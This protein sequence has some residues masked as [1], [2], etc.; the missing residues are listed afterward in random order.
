M[1]PADHPRVVVAVVIHEPH[2]K[3][4]YGSDVSGPAFAKIM[5]GTLRILNIPPDAP[6]TQQKS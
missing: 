3:A 1:S 2:G 6:E 5:E 4:Y